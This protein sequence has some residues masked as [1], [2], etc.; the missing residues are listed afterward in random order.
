M[1]PRKWT[2]MGEGR[3][4]SGTIPVQCPSTLTA[5]NRKPILLSLVL[6]LAFSVPCLNAAEETATTA[7]GKKGKRAVPENP[8]PRT[9]LDRQS[10]K[11]VER[12]HHLAEKSANIEFLKSPHGIAFKEQLVAVDQE[13]NAVYEKYLDIFRQDPAT[14]PGKKMREERD[15][16][17]QALFQKQKKIE[18][19]YETLKNVSPAYRAMVEKH[20]K[21]ELGQLK[22]KLKSQ[23][24]EQEDGKP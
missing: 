6:A 5:M 7:R 8:L 19:E 21:S 3:S 20:L 4:F 12:A 11:R 13:L 22:G 9:P 14:E 15:R 18:A 2:K 1:G 16:Q 24:P 10:Q 23:G 17:L